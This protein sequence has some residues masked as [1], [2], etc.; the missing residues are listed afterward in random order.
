[1]DGLPRIHSNTP[2]V[3]LGHAALQFDDDQ[4]DPVMVS[5]TVNVSIFVYV[6]VMLCICRC[7]YIYVYVYVCKC[8]CIYTICVYI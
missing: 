5:N 8:I 4:R 6:Y 2:E 7:I 3:S 1:M